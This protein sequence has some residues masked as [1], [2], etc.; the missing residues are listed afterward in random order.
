MAPD[1]GRQTRIIGVRQRL[2]GRAANATCAR[3]K[4]PDAVELLIVDELGYVPVTAAGSD[5]A[6]SHN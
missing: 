3:H 6:I 2:F 5:L 4:H 1:S